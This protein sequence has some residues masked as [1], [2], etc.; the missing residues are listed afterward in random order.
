MTNPIELA[1]SAK[2]PAGLFEPCGDDCAAPRA[3]ASESGGG[4]EAV[5]P[6]FDAVQLWRY[7]GLTRLPFEDR[8][9]SPGD[10]AEIVPVDLATALI[11]STWQI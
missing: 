10:V 1:T 11:E 5:C 7:L 6:D 8:L 3:D 9:P 2:G 4:T